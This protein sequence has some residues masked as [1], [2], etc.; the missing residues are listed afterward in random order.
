MH[1][2]G[3][4]PDVTHRNG[5]HTFL[6]KARVAR[7]QE[8]VISFREI[9][10][11]LIN[12]WGMYLAQEEQKKK[13]MD[14]RLG[15]LL[16]SDLYPSHEWEATSPQQHKSPS[17]QSAQSP[18][19][20]DADTMVR[21]G[22]PMT[23]NPGNPPTLQGPM[24]LL[25]PNIGP[26]QASLQQCRQAQQQRMQQQQ[27]MLAL[28][29]INQQASAQPTAAL[30]GCNLHL[31]HQ[32]HGQQQ[33]QCVQ[34]LNDLHTQQASLREHTMQAIAHAQ[35]HLRHEVQ[36]RCD[37]QMH[38]LHTAVLEKQ[39]RIAAYSEQGA[40]S[41]KQEPNND[42]LYSDPFH[43]PSQTQN[44]SSVECVF[45]DLLRSAGHHVTPSFPSNI[46]CRNASI[47]TN[48]MPFSITHGDP[49][50]TG[51]P[52]PSTKKR[53]IDSGFEEGDAEAMAT[54]N[55]S[56]HYEGPGQNTRDYNGQVDEAGSGRSYVGKGK[57]RMEVKTEVIYLD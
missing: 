3:I 43:D 14:R 52:G 56:V 54:Y 50:R 11:E 53:R 51:E 49:R 24:R 42:D 47:P 25:K 17:G 37:Q 1:L 28:Q 9:R 30:H 35:P 4:V 8:D 15:N 12:Y 41:V 6:H 40:Y 36:A 57:G 10:S 34:R 46:M 29:E 5:R 7:E 16:S 19:L 45:P 27:R 48:N 38:G 23:G 31:Q 20:L 39:R 13:E 2:S 33:Q 55:H 32:Q 44:T 18:V 22:I 26:S 21:N